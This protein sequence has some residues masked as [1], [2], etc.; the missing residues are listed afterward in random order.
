[1]GS[2]LAGTHAVSRTSASNWASTDPVL[3]VTKIGGAGVV[4]FAA[5]VVLAAQVT[6]NMAANVV[7]PSNDFSNLNPRRISYV[8]GGR[9]VS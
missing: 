4:I 5:L 9:R 8:T 1:M 3:L 6:T 2:A 7:S